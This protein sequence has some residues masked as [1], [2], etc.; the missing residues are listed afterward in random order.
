VRNIIDNSSAWADFLISKAALILA[1]VIIFAALF[2]LVTGFKNFET[3]KQLDYIAL[4]FKKAV[5]EAGAGNI[6]EEYTEGNSEEFK[7]I[8]YYFN[9]REAFR[10]SPYGR[11]IKIA[12]SGE[13]VSLKA[14]S[15]GRN[16]STAR[17]F[18][19]RIIPSSESVFREKLLSKFGAEGSKKR[20]L[21]ASYTE[22]QAFIQMLGTEEAI[23]NPEERISLKKEL[24]YVEDEEG[25]STFACIL[26]YQ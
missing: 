15:H 12:V 8:S 16:F 13:Y 11:D 18:T 9:E 23:L 6:Q 1:S 7:E 10:A 21:T 2:H 4:D 3:Q 5:D 20:P 22:I 26:V 25:V 17:P 14:K 19:F 24:I